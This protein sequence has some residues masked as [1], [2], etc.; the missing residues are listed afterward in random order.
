MK[1]NYLNIYNNLIKLTRNKKLYLKL[2]KNDTF[3]DRL[4][5][6]F[7]HLALFFKRFKSSIPSKN[8]QELFDF[9]IKHIELSLREIGYGDVTI[10]K[11]MKEY[12]NLF[13]S[14][15]ETIESIDLDNNKNQ[16]FLLKKYLNTDKNM[17]FYIDY[18][19]KYRQFLAKNT[20]NNFTK[21]IISLNF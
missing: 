4:I 21:D 8:L 5:F 11:K 14:I 19:N 10:N 7:L 18:F 20:L 2:E 16:L 1:N 3:S 12:V 17:E 6:L 9:S 15:V 13:Y